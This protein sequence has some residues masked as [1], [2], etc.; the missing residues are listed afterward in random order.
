VNEVKEHSTFLFLF[1]TN[2]RFRYGLDGFIH[3]TGK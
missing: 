3:D 1:D 2:N